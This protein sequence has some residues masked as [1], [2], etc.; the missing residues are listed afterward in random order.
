MT[1]TSPYSSTA[2]PDDAWWASTA[3]FLDRAAAAGSHV[4][5]QFTAFETLPNDEGTLANLTAQVNRFKAHPA[6]LAWYLADEPLSVCPQLT[7]SLS[8][9]LKVPCGRA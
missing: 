4:H 2:A 8:M 6:I 1:L 5:F 3:D 9:H 7:L